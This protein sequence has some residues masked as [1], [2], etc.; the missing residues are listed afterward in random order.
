MGKEATIP[1]SPNL[2]KGPP[3][4]L[5]CGP[6]GRIPAAETLARGAVT[7]LIIKYSRVPARAGQKIRQTLDQWPM[8][9]GTNGILP[10]ICGENDPA[11][12]AEPAI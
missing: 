7:T 6:T 10:A 11:G 1:E 5:E 12:K 3:E 8:R 2:V 9:V 4:I